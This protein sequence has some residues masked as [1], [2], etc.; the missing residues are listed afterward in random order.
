MDVP[1]PGG[2]GYVF[3]AVGGWLL[4]LTTMVFAAMG[5]QRGWPAPLVDIAAAAPAVIAAA[6]FFTAYRLVGRQDEFVRSLF[7][8]RMLIAAALTVVLATAWSSAELMGAPHLPA[9]LLYP[10]I[11]GLFGALTPLVRGTRA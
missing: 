2:K 9:W 7:A 1:F 3:G 4:F 5:R 6:Q 10:L 11:W 8:K